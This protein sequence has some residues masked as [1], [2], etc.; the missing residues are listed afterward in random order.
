MRKL[1]L[2]GFLFLAANIAWAETEFKIITLQHRFAQD[3]LPTIQPMVGEDGSANAMDNNLI[4]RATPERM[5]AIEQVI[6]TLDV[7]RKNVRITVSHDDVRQSQ[8]GRLDASAGASSGNVKVQIPHGADDGVRVGVDS[9]QSNSSLRG[10]EFVSVLDGERAF[11]HVGQSV[12]YAQ[13]WVVLTQHYLT[14]QKTTEFRDITTGFAV[15]PRY[16]G[17]QVE[18]EITPRIAVPN[19]TGFIDFEELSTVVRVTPGQ[20][21]DLG[22]TMQQRDD[23]SRAILSR[24]SGSGSRDTS[25]AIKVD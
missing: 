24:Q 9:R 25:L 4:I 19:R 18:L 14:I 13:E 8:R 20:W 5:Q 16:I 17:G 15:R 22:G 10:S 3:L 12:P 6:A 2:V 1:L 7:A 11:I 23:V 21:F